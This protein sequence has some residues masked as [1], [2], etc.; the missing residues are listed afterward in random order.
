MCRTEPSAKTAWMPVVWAEPKMTGPAAG[1]V[2]RRHDALGHAAVARILED[3][4]LFEEGQDVV[5]PAP[6]GAV[7]GVRPGQVR[8]VG[9]AEQVG[10]GPRQVAG[11]LAA[12]GQ[13]ALD[14]V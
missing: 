1:A 10:G 13:D 14:V 9:A 7:A 11:V 6:L 2:V 5:G 3:G 8:L 12:V 4:V